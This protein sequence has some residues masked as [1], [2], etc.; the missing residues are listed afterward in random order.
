MADDAPSY[1]TVPG[2]LGGLLDKIRQTGVPDKAT[3][4]WLESI[5]FKSS[6]DR[7]MLAVLKQ[8]GFID[9]RGTP[10]PA[11][12]Q[13]RGADHAAVL[14]RSIQLGYDALFA[15]YPEANRCSSEELAHFFSTHSSAG[16]QAI[17]KM[18][19]T[20]NRL[21]EKADFSSAPAAGASPASPSQSSAGRPDESAD[22]S[23]VVTHTVTRPGMTVNV[24][25]QL[26][27]P[28]T[29]DEKIYDAFFSAMRK[30]LLDDDSA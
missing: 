10:T 23:P 8:I 1:T 22:V 7:S 6:N 24:N 27:L 15:T 16:K 30:H 20:F 17:D 3:Q 28:E 21:A 26:T 25:I 12:R 19:S 4:T 2:K 9:D 11:W 29:A 14:G 13:Y 18:V 5:G